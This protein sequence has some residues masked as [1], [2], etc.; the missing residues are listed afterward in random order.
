MNGD[1]YADVIVGASHFDAGQGYGEGAAF[2]FL[3]GASGI[4]NGN[5]STASAQLESDQV[6]GWIYSCVA[7]AG[8]VNGDGYADVLVGRSVPVG[9]L[10]VPRRRLGRRG[11]PSPASAAARL[12]YGGWSVAGAGDVNGDG[13]DDVIVGAPTWFTVEVEDGAAFVFHGGASGIVDGNPD[14]AA[15]QLES[16]QENGLLGY[17]VAGAG[18]VNGDGYSDVV[19]GAPLYDAGDGPVE[20]AAFVFHGGPP[21]IEGGGPGSAATQLVGGQAQ[22]ALG[23]K[24]AGAGDVNGDGY[25]DV[26]VSVQNGPSS[27]A[28]LIYQGSP[29][30]IPNGTPLSAATS[31]VENQN[32]W[33]DMAAAGDVN[34]DGYGDVILGAEFHDAGQEN[35]GAAFVFHGSAQGISDG[36]F[37]TAATRLESNQAFAVLGS[38][39][40]AG[41]VNGDGFGDV[42]VGAWGYSAGQALEGGA[43]VFHGSA[44]GIQGHDPATAAA[45]IESDQADAHLGRSVASAGDVNGDGFA[46]VIVGAQQYDAAHFSDGAAFVFHGSPSGIQGSNPATAAARLEGDFGDTWLG[47]RVAG[48]GDVNGDGY[49]DVIVGAVGY[50][51]ATYI[52]GAAFVFLGSAAGIGDGNPETA[53]AQLSSNQVEAGFGK[54]VAGAGDVNGDGYGDVIV[55]APAFDSPMSDEGAAFVFLGNGSGRPVMARQQ[56]WAGVPVEPWGVS[57]FGFRVSIRAQH[58]EGSGLVRGEIEACPSGAAFDDASCATALTPV[59]VAVGPGA[60]DAVLTHTFTGLEEGALYRWRAR[61]LRAPTTSTQPG[62]TLA[63]NPAHGPWRRVQAQAFEADVRV[64]PEPGRVIS[65]VSGVGLLAALARRRRE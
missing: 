11:R 25:A 17:S 2:V 45:C 63:P 36:G 20:G 12:E 62:I 51:V 16:D 34:G 47:E 18:D 1:G 23:Q 13:Y 32:V 30:G 58:P 27:N 8:D 48:A 19:V 39:A 40:S 49:A 22:A 7:G 3:G 10:R 44:S 24:V 42:I 56:T 53:A 46:D 57:Q 26:M 41:D 21:G 50:R 38:V 35:E 65:L 4:G 64:I 6:S 37:A 29:A 31:L 54:P 9:R 14:T 43:F 52:R 55:G 60:T 15:A 5:P 28:A 61:V 59:W 33:S